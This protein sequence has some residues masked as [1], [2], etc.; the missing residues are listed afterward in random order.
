MDFSQ[1]KA[2]ALHF[3]EM[4]WGGASR[5]AD[6]V[7]SVIKDD[8]VHPVRFS[9]D[10]LDLAAHE[11]V[12][13]SLEP[14][15]NVYHSCC[16][17][18]P[19]SAQPGRRGDAA[20]AV[21]MAAAWVDL[22]IAG[23]AHKSDSLPPSREDGISVLM[24]V[25]PEP[26]L[27][28]DSGWGLYG[29]WLFTQPLS[30]TND[31]RLFERIELGC[32]AA[33]R[34]VAAKSGWDVDRTGDMARILRLP[35]TTNWKIDGDP[36]V[37][38]VIHDSG[39]S[40]V[41][42]DLAAWADTI[43]ADRRLATPF[44]ERITSGYRTKSVE[45]LA[46]RMRYWNE[47][48]RA[49]EAAALAHNTDKCDPPL[50]VQKVRDTVAGIYKRYEPGVKP[51][52]N[53]KANGHGVSG[54]GTFTAYGSIWPEALRFVWEP[55]IIEGGLTLLAGDPGKGKGLITT[56]LVAAMTAGIELPGE[57]PTA[58]EVLW[59]SY[60]ESEAHAIRPRLDVAGADVEKVFK[61]TID[62]GD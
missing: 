31:R 6:L 59:V 14:G 29:W 52:L 28:V 50:P 51:T 61:L 25:D 57:T 60:E 39:R 2:E 34:A 9:S 54:K 12:Q 42:A 58:G 49:A 26:S 40:Y 47:S 16:L 1:R 21:A 18:D 27:I 8:H 43:P 23:P 44:E 41:R 22:D 33:V 11:A 62:R 48:L 55:G 19:A 3:L 38:R 15:A 32:Q 35:G 24:S 13:A 36:R 4:L 5:S 56:A 53:G 46:G 20:D 17:L 10:N 30:L 37:V 45:S 7:V